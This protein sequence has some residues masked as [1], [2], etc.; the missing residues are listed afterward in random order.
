MKQVQLSLS[1]QALLAVNYHG[2]N[3][4]EP[5]KIQMGFWHNSYIYS[6]NDSNNLFHTFITTCCITIHQYSVYH[7]TLATICQCSK[8]KYHCSS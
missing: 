3:L 4:C 1:D 2:P 5:L 7:I 6:W 8:I